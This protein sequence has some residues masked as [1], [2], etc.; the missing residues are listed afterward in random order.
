[1]WELEQPW[2]VNE[3]GT[4]SVYVDDV[5]VIVLDATKGD[6]DSINLKKYLSVEEFK[7]NDDKSIG[8]Q[9]ITRRGLQWITKFMQSDDVV[10]GSF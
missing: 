1:M 10:G 8:L 9:W 4:E 5:M 3:Y 6:T 7:I 2:R